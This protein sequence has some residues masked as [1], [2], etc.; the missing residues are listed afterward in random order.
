MTRN[1]K[2]PKRLTWLLVGAFTLL[3][4][5]LIIPG[6]VLWGPARNSSNSAANS[7]LGLTLIGG[8]LA[9]LGGGI[10]A[11]S[12]FWLERQAAKAQEQAQLRLML[13]VQNDLIGID[14]SKTDISGQGSRART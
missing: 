12:V 14:L 7:D 4:L 13:G 10:V 5:M 6:I 3:F 1:G 2:V 8:S 11:S 9:V